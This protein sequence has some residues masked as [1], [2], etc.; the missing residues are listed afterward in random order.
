[1]ENWK[2]YVFSREIN[3]S[4]IPQRVQNAVIREYVKKQGNH[5]LLSAVEYYMD[6]CYMMLKSMVKEPETYDAVVFYSMHMLPTDDQKRTELIE[7]FLVQNK[8]MYFA[9]ENLSINSR[10]DVQLIQDIFLAKN[11]TD[12]NSLKKRLEAVF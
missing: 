4:F 9:L 10:D 12:S 11:L 3:G 2:G 1:M 5:F 6:N 8:S 7:T